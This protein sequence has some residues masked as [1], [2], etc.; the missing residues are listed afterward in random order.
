MEALLLATGGEGAASLQDVLLMGDA[1]DGAVLSLQELEQSL[2]RLVSVGF[3]A[4]QK[5]K[6]GLTTAFLQ[7]YEAL[8]L[9]TAADGAE[10]PLQVL[11]SRQALS[12]E[13]IDSARAE[14]LKKFKLKAY[15]QQFLEQFG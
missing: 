9:N 10:N 13:G 8:T 2:E 4:V 14:T 12:E 5:N 7:Q 6:L 15:Y 3:V 1:L 11:L